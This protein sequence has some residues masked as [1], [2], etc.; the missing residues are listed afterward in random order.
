[1]ARYS[2]QRYKKI[3]VA[4]DDAM[5]TSRDMNVAGLSSAITLCTELLTDYAAHVADAGETV[6]DDAEEHKALHTAGQLASAVAPLNLAQLIARTN[7]LTTK[8]T[9]H[10]T[11]AAAASPT[12]HQAQ[13][14]P[15]AL[16]A[17]SAVTTLTGAITQ[18]NDIKSKFN[19]HDADAI[20][21]TDGSKHQIAAGAS[22]LGVEIL[23]TEED[24]K[25]GDKV[26][27]GILKAGT[28][29]VTGVS[30]TAQDGGIVF[31]FSADPQDDAIISYA[32]IS[33]GL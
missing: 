4:S 24:V 28:G 12:F 14:T 8:Y 26:V 19:A 9:L 23:V 10:N 13:G 21:H 17:T 31:K 29:T 32:A 6:G 11:D 20:A 27:W 18:L 25:L 30:A 33:G 3:V 1:M 7:D 5:T 15:S 22:A 2:R 16:S